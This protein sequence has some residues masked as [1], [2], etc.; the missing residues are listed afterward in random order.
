MCVATDGTGF[1][2]VWQGVPEKSDSFQGYAAAVS[3]DGK[4]GATLREVL[5]VARGSGSIAAAPSFVGGTNP[6]VPGAQ[7]APQ[8]PPQFI[9][10]EVAADRRITF[11]VYAPRAQAAEPDSP[12]PV[13][14]EMRPAVTWLPV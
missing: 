4:V 8:Q 11:R 5:E 14:P 10:A 3:P 9:A 7:G 1:L 2:A 6:A 12:E 13:V